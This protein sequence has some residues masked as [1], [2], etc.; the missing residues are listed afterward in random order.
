M[1][2]KC[3]RM[4][5]M[6]CVVTVM[7]CMTGC[8]GQ[9]QVQSE[10]QEI[11]AVEEKES[12]EAI[13][14]SKTPAESESVEVNQPIQESNVVE[15]DKIAE[16]SVP[17]EEK[18]PLEKETLQD[19]TVDYGDSITISCTV[20]EQPIVWED[21]GETVFEVSTS[22]VQFQNEFDLAEEVTMKKVQKAIGKYEGDSFTLVFEGGDGQY[23]YEYT[24]QEIVDKPAD[25]VTY[26][27]KVHVSYEMRSFGVDRSGELETGEH[28]LHL[29]DTDLV[30]ADD[31]TEYSTDIAKERISNI[32]GKGIGDTFMQYQ[33]GPEY[34]DKYRYTITGID[35]AVEYGD[36]IKVSVRQA[37][38]LGGEEKKVSDY[39]KL[40]IEV[41][42]PKGTIAVAGNELNM[43]DT[44]LF[45]KDVLGMHIGDKGYFYTLT[46]SV[47][48]NYC[49]CVQDIKSGKAIEP[50][51]YIVPLLLSEEENSVYFCKEDEKAPIVYAI[52]TDPENHMRYHYSGGFGTTYFC[53]WSCSYESE[54]DELGRLVKEIYGEPWN[55]TYEYKYNEQNICIESKETSGSSV[56]YQY[57]NDE[58]VHI[59][60]EYYISD[61]ETAIT[62]YDK[63]NKILTVYAG[64]GEEKYKTIWEYDDYGVVRK[65]ENHFADG[66]NYTAKYDEW[67]AIQTSERFE[68]GRRCLV[69]YLDFSGYEYVIT[70]Y[71]EAGNVISEEEFYH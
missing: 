29:V 61:N 25:T 43:T 68:N 5:A 57:Y 16:E 67:G 28:I 70:Y 40:E 69:E 22:S 47:R 42:A 44:M 54:Y 59:R 7:C 55:C 17:S 50:E 35:K 71:D 21:A 64:D 8:A 53:E 41:L 30:M 9:E 58:G 65:E 46:D 26:G 56:C 15:V 63:N 12:Q 49:F 14:E 18:S 24:I 45:F 39:E 37:C 36:T 31:E 27:D 33:G 38:I 32:T 10:T 52:V 11:P 4:L 34:E 13:G 48:R 51:Y 60:T 1:K 2:N 19:D 23:F 62:V 66:D 3:R 20:Y 6:W